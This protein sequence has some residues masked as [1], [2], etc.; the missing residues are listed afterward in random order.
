MMT[1]EREGAIVDLKAFIYGAIFIVVAAAAP[2][3]RAAITPAAYLSALDLS[4][5]A[6]QP[7]LRVLRQIKDH[8]S[9]AARRFLQMR[10]LWF[11]T[12]SR[13]SAPKLARECVWMY[14]KFYDLL[15]HGKQPGQIGEIVRFAKDHRIGA[16]IRSSAAWLLYLST[17]KPRWAVDALRLSGTEVGVFQHAKDDDF[18]KV[19]TDLLS[20]AAQTPRGTPARHHPATVTVRFYYLGLVKAAVFQRANGEVMRNLF[21]LYGRMLVLTPNINRWES[22]A[23]QA[24]LVPLRVYFSPR[25][26][27]LVAKAVSPYGRR[28]LMEFFRALARQG[29]VLDLAQVMHDLPADKAAVNHAVGQVAATSQGRLKKQLEHFLISP[30]KVSNRPWLTPS[31]REGLKVLQQQ[32]AAKAA[33]E[34]HRLPAWL[35]VA[36]P[37]VGVRVQPRDA[38]ARVVFTIQNNSQKKLRVLR[39]WTSC[40]CT[41]ATVGTHT[42]PAGGSLRVHAKVRLAGL[43]PPFQRYVFLLLG[44]RS[45]RQH[46]VKVRLTLKVLGR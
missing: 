14:G 39:L 23:N 22:A 19:L 25:A 10:H 38:F 40:T 4:C 24:H 45:H 41:S 43:T 5:P 29:L 16:G 9:A 20:E 30:P 12:A 46:P 17:K 36:K 15:S 8:P 34:G 13:A 33:A 31:R 37:S 3:A 21:A 6:C 42:I 44:S 35:V 1:N 7:Y 27:P 32:Q 26:A 11:P 18:S 2:A 28:P